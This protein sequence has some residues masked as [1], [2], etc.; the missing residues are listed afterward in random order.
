MKTCRI[1]DVERAIARA[2]PP[3]RA[4]DWDHVGL[5]AGDPDARVRG[6]I[7][8]LD[9]T[10]EAIDAA[11]SSGANVLVTHHPAF[12]KPPKWITPG[13]GPAGIAFAALSKGVALISA[14][15]NLDR[16]AAAQRI[17]PEL[18][19]LTPIRPLERSLQPRVVVTVYAPASSADAILS[20]MSGA[21]AG[22]I[23]EYEGCSF[24]S[25][26]T[27]RFCAPDDAA[28]AV[29]KPGECAQ[30]QEVRIEVV[31][32][33]NRAR[34]VISA[35]AAA[36]PYEEPLI[37][38]SEV[39]SARNA[40]R[41]GMLSS[42]SERTLADIAL[43]SADVFGVVPRVWGDAETRISRVATATGSASSLI[44]D[45]IASGAQVLVAGEVRYHDALDAVSAGLAIV[46]VGHDVSE[47]PLVGLLESAV[48]STPG[49]DD[50]AIKTLPASAA[51]WTTSRSQ[52]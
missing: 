50:A 22:R 4:E 8:A 35:A 30:A 15:T 34:G 38:A 42:T 16:D 9:P 44:G 52:G 6:V 45:A 26:G 47:W 19:G 32:P 31:C 28:P 5:I 24:I 13:R 23:G 11:A 43:A 3:D 1:G 12:L 27:G 20:A 41:L 39:T 29:G 37:T 10:L 17:I 40:A 14:H 18:L 51:W 46:E 7:L 49:L 21:G 48:R 2:F 25:G 36:H 33:S